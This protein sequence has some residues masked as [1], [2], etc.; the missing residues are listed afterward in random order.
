MSVFP[1][2]SDRYRLKINLKKIRR[3]KIRQNKYLL[4][5]DIACYYFW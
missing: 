3:K 5:G 1:A 4:L 2:F